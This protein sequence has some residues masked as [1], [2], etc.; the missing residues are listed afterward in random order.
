MREENLKALREK[1]Q[2]SFEKARSVEPAPKKMSDDQRLAQQ[3]TYIELLY[4]AAV[5]QLD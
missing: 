3:R 4:R 5:K 1:I 2:A